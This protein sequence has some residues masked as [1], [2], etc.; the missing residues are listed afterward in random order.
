MALTLLSLLSTPAAFGLS[1]TTSTATALIIILYIISQ[2]PFY[3]VLAYHTLRQLRLVASIHAMVKE[4]NLFQLFPVDAFS[5]LTARTGLA[6]V[7]LIYYTYF[8]FSSLNVRGSTPGFLGNVS[9]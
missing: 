7:L 2:S 4:I 9:L 1:P 8:F 3:A 5:S 6:F